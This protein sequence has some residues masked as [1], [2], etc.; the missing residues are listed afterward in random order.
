M[1]ALKHKMAVA[2]AIAIVVFV[3]V[4]FVDFP[5]SVPDFRR[6]SGGGV[7]LDMT[8]AFSEDALYARLAS[9]GAE[10]RSNYAFRNVTADVLLPLALLPFLFLW[11]RRALDRLSL[12]RSSRALLL[13]IP[14]LYVVFD[15][16]ENGAVLAMLTNF[17]VRMPLLSSVLPWLTI[18]KRTASLLAI[19]GPLI[20]FAFSLI[21]TRW[22]RR[23][24]AA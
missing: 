22:A 15:L 14:V 4:H 8:P 20:I 13:A 1:E 2:F 6:A 10:G 9:Y 18:I 24:A 16:A 21:R 7:L 3:A 11:M 5:G 17:P 12:G 23:H 19:L